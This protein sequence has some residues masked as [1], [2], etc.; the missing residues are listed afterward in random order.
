MRE[1]VPCIRGPRV[2]VVDGVEYVSVRL[3]SFQP[4]P[5]AGR[6]GRVEVTN[7]TFWRDGTWRHRAHGG[8]L[9]PMTPDELTGWCDE[10]GLRVLDLFGA[11]D[12]SPFDPATS[13]DLILIAEW[14]T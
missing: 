12:R 6:Q 13:P 4:D 9:Y 14:T 2:T 3:F 7:V 11:Y 1:Q 5:S 10:A 8:T